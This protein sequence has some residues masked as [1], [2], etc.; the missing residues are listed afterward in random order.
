MGSRIAISIVVIV[1]LMLSLTIAGVNYMSQVNVRMNDIVNNN[2]VK[3][4]MAHIM[5]NS[6]RERALNMYIMTIVDDDFQG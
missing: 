5:Q 1:V 6:L 3:M 2:N 4:E